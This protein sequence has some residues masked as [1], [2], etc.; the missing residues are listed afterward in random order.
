MRKDATEFSFTL[1]ELARVAQAEIKGDNRQVITSLAPISTAEKGDLTY[2]SSD[3][4]RKY[5]NQ[6]RASAVLLTAEVLA[7]CPTTALIV[8]NPELA[9][10]RIAALF[11]R[12][13]KF[14]AGI[15]PTAVIAEDCRVDPSAF[16][17]AGCVLEKGVRVGARAMIGAGTVI[18]ENCHIEDDCCLHNRVTLYPNVTLQARSIIHSGAVIG[19]DGFGYANENGR[20]VKIP[21]LGRVII[22][23]DVEIGANTT[24]DRGALANTIIRR[25]VKIDNQVQIGHN[26][27]I[28]E[29]TIIAGCVGIAGSTKIGKQCLIG[30]GALLNGHITI[31]DGTTIT[32]ATTVLRSITE[33]G[34]Y[35]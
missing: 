24:V 11:E 29:D 13:K 35:T 14:V 33:P 2:L 5:L 27:E 15:H 1:E 19:A 18:G 22:E 28:G 20:W 6:T 34:I 16:I 26:V 21:Q 7:Q 23:E 32:G 25:G 31:A 3:A 12:R 30:G 9:F 4:Y 8:K 10:A 17:G